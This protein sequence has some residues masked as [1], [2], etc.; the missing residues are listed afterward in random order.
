MWWLF[1]LMKDKCK[2]NLKTVLSHFL[3]WTISDKI[4]QNELW[5]QKSR[6]SY[7][8]L[9]KLYNCKEHR[10]KTADI[11]GWHFLNPEQR[12]RFHWRKVW[13]QAADQSRRKKSKFLQPL[14]QVISI[15]KKTWE[16]QG[17][18]HKGRNLFQVWKRCSSQQYE[19]SH[20]S[21]RK[22]NRRK[23]LLQ[24]LLQNFVN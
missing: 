20:E 18:S 7:P 8:S 14:P 13:N 4:C 22:E 10:I 2:I 23:S 19:V 5:M 9:H 1:C 17:S 6:Y 11:F 16:T 24:H 15:W 21:S 12:C 3:E